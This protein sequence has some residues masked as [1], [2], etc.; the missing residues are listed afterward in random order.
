MEIF[1]FTDVRE[2]VVHSQSETGGVG[3][4]GGVNGTFLKD[5]IVLKRPFEPVL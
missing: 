2:R 1:Y 4:W 3:G 5:L